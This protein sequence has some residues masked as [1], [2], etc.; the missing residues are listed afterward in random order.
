[1]KKFSIKISSTIVVITSLLLSLTG[2]GGGGSGTANTTAAGGADTTAAAADTTAA[3][4]GDT[5]Q[6]AS[7]D[8]KDTLIIATENETPSM[9]TAGHNAVAGSYMNDMTH[10]GLF[11]Y[12]MEMNPIPDLCAEYKNI[13]PTE[14]EFKIKEGVKFHDGTTMTA[15]DIKASLD[16]AKNHQDVVMYTKSMT[17]VEVID[18]LT[19]KITTDGPQANLLNDL[20][21][22]S[23]FIVPKA[24]IDSGND[25]NKNPIGT[26][27]YKF[28]SWTLGD[29]LD[30]EKFDDYFDKDNMPSIKHVT[31]KVIPEGSSRTIALE[32]QEADL[33]I[34]VA[35]TDFDRLS[36][37]P[38]IGVIEVPSL[39][40]N[41]IMINNEKAPFD[42][43]LVRKAINVGIDKQSVVD[44]ALDGHGKVAISCTPV[45]M[46]GESEE[47]AETYDVEKAKQYLTESGVDPASIKLDIICSNDQKKRA[48]EVIQANLDEIGIASELVSMDLATYLSVTTTTDYVAAIGGYTSNDMLSYVKGV[49]HSS[50]IN[51]SN[52]SRLND[53]KV[54]ELIDKAIQTI[55]AKER[56]AIL[57]ELAAYLNTLVSSVPLYQNTMIRAFNA[58]LD[59]VAVSPSGTLRVNNI[60]WK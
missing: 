41:Y 50:S 59:G 16:E 2:C 22:H 45:G 47:N 19:V 10:N 44:V 3:P 7:S 35:T 26:G 54:D 23:N 1:M 8:K 12:D 20:A 21:H 28:V 30:F 52:K 51:G 48:G 4:S 60:K 42:N 31:W 39:S 43:P 13:S 37:N 17:G 33:V 14:W 6:A 53:P 18:P 46:M 36:T 9:T 24:L 40:H 49:Y 11:R 34:E 15:D 58:G 25:F 5:T 57:K 55:D 56:E 38:E 29:K 27:P 32:A